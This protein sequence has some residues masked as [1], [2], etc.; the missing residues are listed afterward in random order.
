MGS[1]AIFSVLA[2]LFVFAIVDMSMNTSNLHSYENTYGYSKYISARDIAR[3]SIQVALRKIDTV[4]TITSTTVTGSLGGGSFSVSV[5]PVNDTTLT[6]AAISTFYDTTYRIKTKMIR[7]P[8]KLP[9]GLFN[10][11]FGISSDSVNFTY[12]PKKDTID[13]R[14]HD[15]NGN[16]LPTSPDSVPAVS[17]RT[18][19]DSVNVVNG[20]KD[21]TT[22]IGTPKIKVDPGITDPNLFGDQF[23]SIADRLYSAS[24][25]PTPATQIGNGAGD[26]VGTSTNPVIVFCDGTN[27][28]TGKTDGG[29]NLKIK[30]G[31]GLLV[32]KGN[33]GLSGGATWHGA[34][35][36][37][38]N[39]NL[40]LSGSSGN[41]QIYGAIL[42][43]G[44]SKG[45]YSLKGNT[46]VLYS[47]DA[48][49]LALNKETPN[50]YSI[51]DWYEGY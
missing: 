46:K 29:F 3:N 23:R 31:W 7:K 38:G 25:G 39:T 44:T 15:V 26:T 35:I 12:D 1:N 16:V 22:V 20:V 5:T 43:G 14:A 4:K 8:V 30:D 40:A 33:L 48:I 11:A 32:V 42:F 18:A 10:S 51:V 19:V 36:C 34:I 28:T 49:L 24:S 6:L 13:G 37:F 45:D 27:S 17:G 47:K 50:V 21:M 9:P 2:L 41:S